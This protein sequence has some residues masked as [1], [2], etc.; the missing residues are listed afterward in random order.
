MVSPA[1][2]TN[3]LRFTGEGGAKSHSVPTGRSVPS[4]FGLPKEISTQIQSLIDQKYGPGKYRL[5]SIP[6]VVGFNRMYSSD[7]YHAI[8]LKEKSH[9]PNVHSNYGAFLKD[10]K[11]DIE[12]AE[13]EYRKAIELDNKHINALGNLANLLWENDDITQAEEFYIRALEMDPGNEL[14]SWNYARF[15]INELRSI[16]GALGI[17][18][19]GISAHPENG[20]LQLTRAEL[21]LRK[22]LPSVALKGFKQARERGA[23]QARTEQGT[24]SPYI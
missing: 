7:E 9:D 13:R 17:L 3:H 1:C 6:D 10:K 11:G 20:R 5:D 12:G 21:S 8:Q 19:G 24:P 18:D 23:D 22:G 15:L 2:F 16:D 4:F 14:V